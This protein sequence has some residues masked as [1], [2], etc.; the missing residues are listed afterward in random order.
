MT[1]AILLAPPGGFDRVS[2]TQLETRS[3][4]PDEIRVRFMPHRSIITIM[5]S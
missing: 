2:V 3:P 1:R 4:G 5:R